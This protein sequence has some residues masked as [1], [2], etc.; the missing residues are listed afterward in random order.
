MALKKKRK[1]KS[2]TKKNIIFWI[3]VLVCIG[4][5]ALAG[6]K[7]VR[8][9]YQMRQTGYK[10]GSSNKKELNDPPSFGDVA[11]FTTYNARLGSIEDSIVALNTVTTI[12]SPITWTSCVADGA[13]ST[14]KKWGKIYQLYMSFTITDTSCSSELGTLAASYRSP[15]MAVKQSAVQNAS[16]SRLATI[17]LATTGKIT[18]TPMT[19]HTYHTT[20]MY[21]VP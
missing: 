6:Y 10:A 13:S 11:A 3:L 17:T 21:A 16:S 15:D 7:I 5:F 14:I 18:M 8:N 12:N 19:A 2:N 4:I 20:M 1:T 9:I